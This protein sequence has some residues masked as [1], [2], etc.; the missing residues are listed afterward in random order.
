MFGMGLTLTP[1]NFRDVWK[2]KHLVL[3]GLAAQ[4]T[5]MPLVALGLSEMLALAPAVAIGIVL[6]GSCP[7]GTA[8]NVITYLA[9]GNVALSVTITLCSTL[10]A[11]LATPLL[12]ELLVGERIDVPIGSMMLVVS[13]IV[14]FPVILGLVVRKIMGDRLKTVIHVFPYL[15]MFTIVFVIA[16]VMAKNQETILDL[17]WLIAL[18]VILHNLIG[19]AAGYGWGKILKA[20]ETDCR[21]LAIEV[22]MQNSGLAAAL[23]TKFFTPIAALPAALFSLWHNLSGVALASWWV[24]KK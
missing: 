11:P 19:L 5:V 9:G 15:S 7:G 21:T 2:H 13:K 6:V 24:G 23:A 22:G 18:A 12:I 10:L 8:S 20:N 4:F 3:A 17:P 16:I 1:E 14:L